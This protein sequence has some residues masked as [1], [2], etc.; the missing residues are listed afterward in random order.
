MTKTTSTYWNVFEPSNR[1]RWTPI[2]GLEQMAE[3]LTLSLDPVTGEYTRLTRFL[4]GADTSAF[5]GKT[6]A[7]PEEV[8]VVSGRLYDKAFALWLEAGHYASRPAGELHGPFLT[9]VGCVVLEVSFP[10][11][12]GNDLVARD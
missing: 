3:E 4:P 5:G 12:T 10:M 9:D 7:Y 8:F 1:S 11:R 2:E 6:H